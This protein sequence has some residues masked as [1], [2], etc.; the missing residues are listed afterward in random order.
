MRYE[1]RV[2]QGSKGQILVEK[3]RWLKEKLKLI[4]EDHEKMEVFLTK[5]EYEK[6]QKDT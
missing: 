5:A 1:N 4:A 3:N 2:V 6:H